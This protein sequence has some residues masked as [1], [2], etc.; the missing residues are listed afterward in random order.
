[1][2]ANAQ[3]KSDPAALSYAAWATAR[4]LGLVGDF[5]RAEELVELSLKSA[6]TPLD[7]IWARQTRAWI[8]CRARAGEAAIEEAR[9]A[10]TLAHAAKWSTTSLWCALPDAY[11]AAGRWQEARRAAEDLLE[12]ATVHGM[13][14]TRAALQRRMGEIALQT[15]DLTRPRRV[16]P[17]L[18]D[19]R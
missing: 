1:M 18:G 3:A 8:W 11:F 16:G 15:G 19:S 10:T 12:M 4:V 5:G 2:L 17:G 6:V 14:A 9:A 7:H 13:R